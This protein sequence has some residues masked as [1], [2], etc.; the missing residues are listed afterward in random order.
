MKI[1]VGM[2]FTSAGVEGKVISLEGPPKSPV[3]GVITPKTGDPYVREF[4]LEGHAFG[5]G[6]QFDLKPIPQKWTIWL[7]VGRAGSK[8]PFTLTYWH[9]EE[10]AK[11]QVQKVREAGIV[12]QVEI[13]KV[14]GQ[15]HDQD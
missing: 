1:T 14:E 9:T 13:Q 15:W 3:V 8:Y 7:V 12:T 4:S 11:E 10:A 2:R 5:W 6:P